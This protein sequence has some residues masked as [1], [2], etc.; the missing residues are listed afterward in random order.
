[1][2]RERS[3]KLLCCSLGCGHRPVHRQCPARVAPMECPATP[4]FSTPHPQQPVPTKLRTFTKPDFQL[5]N[6]DSNIYRR[7]FSPC[8][9]LVILPILRHQLHQ[10][11]LESYRAY[12]GEQQDQSH[13]RTITAGLLKYAFHRLLHDFYKAACH[14]DHPVRSPDIILYPARRVRDRFAVC[15]RAGLP[16]VRHGWRG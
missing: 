11:I 3:L 4:S 5:Q 15:C 8:H 6:V 1:M 2:E 14:G 7:E 12:P 13:N 9:I 16:R 10:R